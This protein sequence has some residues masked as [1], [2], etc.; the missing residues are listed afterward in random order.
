MVVVEIDMTEFDARSRMSLIS[1]TLVKLEE[2]GIKARAWF[3]GAYA[4]GDF[5]PLEPG[6]LARKFLTDRLVRFTFT[7]RENA[8]DD[9]PVPYF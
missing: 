6:T 9:N 3:G 8:A 4:Y 2:G 1:W 7:P 5:Y